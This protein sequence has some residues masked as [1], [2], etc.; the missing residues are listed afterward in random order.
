M[1]IAPTPMPYASPNWS[2]WYPL[3]TAV[4]SPDKPTIAQLLSSMH[5]TTQTIG[6]MMVRT[7]LTRTMIG[8][9]VIVATNMWKC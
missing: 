9:L 1:T 6:D 4:Q 8:N 7:I 5:V 2:V 3:H